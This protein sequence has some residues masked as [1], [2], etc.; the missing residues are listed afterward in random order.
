MIIIIYH[1]LNLVIVIYVS[2]KIKT[3]VGEIKLH[4]EFIIGI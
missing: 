4:F 1:T 2:K 3:L